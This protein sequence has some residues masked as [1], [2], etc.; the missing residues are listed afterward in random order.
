MQPLSLDGLHF[1]LHLSLNS[2]LLDVFMQ[3]SATPRLLRRPQFQDATP[4]LHAVNI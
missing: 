1:A 2:A 3:K 4:F